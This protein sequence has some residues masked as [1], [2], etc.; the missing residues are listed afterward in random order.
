MQAPEQGLVQAPEQGL[1]RLGRLVG[2]VGIRQRQHRQSEKRRE[3]TPPTQTAKP[4]CQPLARLDG[5]EQPLVRALALA[6]VLVLEQVRQR[7]G[8]AEE[9][10][11]VS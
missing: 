5:P 2:Q 6:L 10:M 4:R 8:V 11:W 3:W 1:E 9:R 7:R